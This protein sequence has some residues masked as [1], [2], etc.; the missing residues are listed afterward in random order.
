MCVVM[1]GDPMRLEVRCSFAIILEQQLPYDKYC[2]LLPWSNSPAM[3]MWDISLQSEMNDVSPQ[4]WSAVSHTTSDNLWFTLWHT[5]WFY[6]LS[7]FM[8]KNMHHIGMTNSG[9]GWLGVKRVYS[10]VLLCPQSNGC[11]LTCELKP[12]Q[13][14]VGYVFVILFP[15]HKPGRLGWHNVSYPG[16]A[17]LLELDIF[18]PANRG[19]WAVSSTQAAYRLQQ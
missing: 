9:V 5:V 10:R 6:T 11:P 16:C 2:W 17:L 4:Q 1:Q 15:D 7:K 3:R 19:K 18:C 14:C 13:S 8:Q 12:C